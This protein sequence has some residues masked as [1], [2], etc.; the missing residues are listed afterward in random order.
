MAPGEFAGTI[1]ATSNS[2]SYGVVPNLVGVN[3]LQPGESTPSLTHTQHTRAP[4]KPTH[5]AAGDEMAKPEH[6]QKVGHSKEVVRARTHRSAS[7]RRI[8]TLPRAE[9]GLGQ[10]RGGTGSAEDAG[11]AGTAGRPDIGTWQ[12]PRPALSL[13]LTP[14]GKGTGPPAAG[15]GGIEA[16]ER[17]L[18]PGKAARPRAF[19][20]VQAEGAAPL[21]EQ[22]E[23][24]ERGPRQRGVSRRQVLA[25]GRHGTAGASSRAGGRGGD[26]R[27]AGS[28]GETGRGGARREGGAGR[29]GPPPGARRRAGAH[30][31]LGLRVGARGHRGGRNRPGRS[32]RTRGPRRSRRERGRRENPRPRFPRCPPAP[33]ALVPASPLLPPPRAR[34][35]AQAFTRTGKASRACAG[36][37]VGSASPPPAMGRYHPLKGALEEGNGPIPGRLH[38]TG[39]SVI[40]HGNN[41]RELRSVGR[42]GKNDYKPKTF[43]QACVF[44][45]MGYTIV[46]SRGP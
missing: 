33:P 32:L 34:A 9:E 12:R 31:G 7:G 3:S 30:R 2:N 26:C 24:Q 16:P 44:Q 27:S 28:A 42:W 13:R 11:A 1:P 19:L 36:G 8:Y 14:R 15:P 29:A 41:C 38:K 23:Q 5:R 10:A 17:P 6:T 25:E 20:P 35:P 22:A 40:I 45:S 21:V 39:G 43:S 46:I 18:G 4:T 37:F